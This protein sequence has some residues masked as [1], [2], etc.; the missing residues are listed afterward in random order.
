M[1]SANATD[2]SGNEADTVAGPCFVIDTVAPVITVSYTSGGATVTPEGK[3]KSYYKETVVVQNS[4]EDK[5]L[6][7]EG[8]DAVI[9]GSK[10]DGTTVDLKVTGW[11]H[12]EGSDFWTAQVELS[13]D[14]EYALNGIL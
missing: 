7:E 5:H 3:D 14:G 2:M 9:T 1:F 12:S 13:D 6:L 11:T 4:I 8:I 10:A